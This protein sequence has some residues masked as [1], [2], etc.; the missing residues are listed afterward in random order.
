M[1][2]WNGFQ[3]DL[4]FITILALL[5]LIFTAVF[6]LRSFVGAGDVR[7]TRETALFTFESLGT[8]ETVTYVPVLTGLFVL[9]VTGLILKKPRSQT[10]IYGLGLVLVTK[11]SFLSQLSN[12]EGTVS[13]VEAS[14]VLSITVRASG[15]VV[16]Q[17]LAGYVLLALFMIKLIIVIHSLYMRH[18][19]EKSKQPHATVQSKN[20][21]PS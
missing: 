16:A 4:L 12:L 20:E 5:H 7:I 10:L 3:K 6:P 14:G 18:Q 1:A 11:F 2:K 19:K 13:D 9:I 15:D 21:V 8:G 17:D